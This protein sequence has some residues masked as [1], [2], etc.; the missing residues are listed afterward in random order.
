MGRVST[1]LFI[2]FIPLIFIIEMMFLPVET[3]VAGSVCLFLFFAV[4]IVFV[5]FLLF[6]SVIA[7]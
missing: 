5:Y 7:F 1:V 4:F 3:R 2:L 6:I